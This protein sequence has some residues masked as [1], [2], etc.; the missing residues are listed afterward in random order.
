MEPAPGFR[1]GGEKPPGIKSHGGDPYYIP[2]ESTIKTE[3]AQPA[4]ALD[5]HGHFLVAYE[6]GG[7][8]RDKDGIFAHYGV[9]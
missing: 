6:R 1:S 2:W 5:A 9:L 8:S 7:D 4:I 3:V